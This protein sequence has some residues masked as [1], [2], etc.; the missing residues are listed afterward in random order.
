MRRREKRDRPAGGRANNCAAPDRSRAQGPRAGAKK[1]PKPGISLPAAWRPR[2]WLRKPRAREVPGPRSG[3][4]TAPPR[5][6]SLDRRPRSRG[7]TTARQ[8]QA[9]MGDEPILASRPAKADR[10]CPWK[11]GTGNR[12]RHEM[13]RRSPS[14]RRRMERREAPRV[15]QEM[16]ATLRTAAPV[17]APPPRRYANRGD[18]RT[19]AYPGPQRIRAMAHALRRKPKRGGHAM[20]AA[21]RNSPL[22]PADAGNQTLPNRGS[23]KN[24]IPA[25]AGMSGACGTTLHPLAA[26]PFTRS[27]PR[28]WGSRPCQTACR[29]RTGFPLARE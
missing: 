17:G 2:A 26:R 28:T 21:L 16:R 14:G 3:G 22:I 9:P 11:R 24:W 18:M 15:S 23:P 29:Q 13:V 6:A 8:G 7:R 25:C 27:S 4:T 19:T 10:G 12:N 20:L 5:G 1:A